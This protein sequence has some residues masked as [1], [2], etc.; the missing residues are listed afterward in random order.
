MG[1]DDLTNSRTHLW[2]ATLA[3]VAM[4][5]LLGGMFVCGDFAAAQTVE[6]PKDE[7]A[8]ASSASLAETV[9]DIKVRGNAK[10]ESE[11]IVTMLKTKRGERLDP[12]AVRDDIRTLFELGYF[13]DVRFLKV[14]VLGGIDVIVQV[15]EKPAIIAIKY[16]GME[17][18]TEDSIK[19][20]METKLYTIVNEATITTDV[21][22][23][24]KQY[25]EK[26]FYLARV[27]YTLEK[28]GATEVELTFVVE[29]GG[30]LLVGQ[31]DI[32][33]NVFY[34]D[35]DIIEKL[36]SRP[37]TRMSAF[38]SAS[39][40]QDDF[41][42]RDLEFISFYYRDQGFAEVKVAKPHS[43]LDPDREFVRITFAVEEGLQYNVGTLKVSGDLL[44]T[45]AELLEKMKLKPGA[46]F[47]HSHFLKD[48]EMLG[49]KYGDLGYAFADVNPKT[50]FNRENRTV[51][52]NYEI[53]KGEKVYFGVMTVVGNTKTRDNVVRREFEVADSELF[54]GTR[55]AETKK[56]I[57]RLGY[58]EEVQV[59]RERDAD[60]PT[61]LNY[62]IKVKEKPT[63]QL[64]AALGFTPGQGGSS[65]SW[66]GQGRYDEQN[67]SG[68]GWKTNLTG[69]WNG[70]R[71]YGLEAG[72]TNPRV[73]DS[74][75]LA[76][77]TAF[78]KNDVRNPLD[79]VAIEDRRTG[80]TFFI[81]RR[82]IELI[83][84]RLTYK[85]ERIQQISDSYIL[86]RFREEGISSSAIFSLS[87]TDTDNF[88]D[89]TEG[90]EVD[91]R[92]QFTGGPVLRGDNEYMETTLDGSWFIPLDFSEEYRTYFKLHGFLGYI[93]PMGDKEVPFLERYRLGG[94]NDLRGYK[95][96]A[97]GPK[98]SV[99]RAPGD[100]ASRYNKGGD[101]KLYFQFEYFAPLIPQA[102]IKALVF[103]D[104]GRVYDDAEALELSGLYK[105]VGF[106]LRWIT[107]IAPFR[108]E[109]AYPILDGGKL[110]D[111][112]IIF[113]IGY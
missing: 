23:I 88:I 18:V 74:D 107:P 82:I 39:L 81:G 95:T 100:A 70:G 16:E 22:M 14:D 12:I 35:G 27:N 71:N 112:E 69:R 32:L 113:Y 2:S 78:I 31:V 11:A 34:K 46:L 42:K 109:W 84:G 79:D 64:Q 67:Q 75:W 21:R 47:R 43:F 80:G 60:D 59:I 17:E 53:T 25:A 28:K 4:S 45:E 94:P 37:I 104:A 56:N 68:K 30:K 86:D 89:P 96:W 66:F 105:D 15:A 40:F 49:D 19:D 52:I 9:V 33:G 111:M 102:G 98:F 55:L 99:L 58:F 5:L 92:Q 62:K 1:A 54:S 51:D 61:Q 97:L 10:V 73:N 38:G 91:L 20:K 103:T 65:A 24:E 13:S 108:F 110:G 44:F 57:N 93:Y 6:P 8:P 101:K 29:E 36:A 83:R 63:G 50:T 85:I 87:R 26:G 7:P 41:L 76:G 72:F 3:S 48:I 90:T 106:G 77:T